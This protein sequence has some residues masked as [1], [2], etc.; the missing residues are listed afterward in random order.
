[1]FILGKVYV[2]GNRL[3]YEKNYL[4]CINRLGLQID[5][6]M[7]RTEELHVF[8]QKAF[9]REPTKQGGKSLFLTGIGIICSSPEFWLSSFMDYCVELKEV[10]QSPVE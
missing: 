4:M 8:L 2:T 10:N 3:F 5:L 9:R 6:T 1:V 7:G